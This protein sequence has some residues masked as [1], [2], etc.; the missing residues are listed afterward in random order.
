MAD[1]SY[2]DAFCVLGRAL[3]TGPDQPATVDELLGAMDHFGIHE[4]LAIDSLCTSSNPMA[5]NRR[6]LERTRNQPRLH[7]AWAG[8]MTHSREFPEPREFVAQMRDQGVGA[9][10]LFY[11]QWA[12]P[13]EDWAID[14]LLAE[15]EANRAPLFLCPNS[16]MEPGRID[17]SDWRNI[18][19]LCRKFPDLPVVVTENRLYRG[20]RPLYEALAACPNLK[21]DLSAL[22]LHRRIEFICREFGAERLVWGSCLPERGPGASLMQLNY[23]DITPEELALIAGG[24]LRNLLSWN[25]KVEPVGSQVSFPAPVDSLHRKVRERASFRDEKFYDCHGHIGWCCPYHV[26]DDTPQVLVAEMDKLGV[27]VTCVFSLQIM[28]D[29]EYGTDE[30]LEVTN[31]YPN[32]FIGFT[33]VNPKYGEKLMLQELERGL[34]LGMQG[35]KLLPSAYGSYDVSGPLIDVA[36]RFAHEHK[37]MILSHTW[38]SADRVRQLCRDFPDAL[39]ISGHSAAHFGAVCQEFPNLY[40]CTCPFLGWN[41]T[42]HFVQIYGA[43]RL[44]FGS[45][46]MDLPIAWGLGPIL[47]AKIS[48]ADKR[49]ILGGNLRRLMDQYHTWPHGWPR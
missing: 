45:D 25:P 24:N 36:C 11:G 35:V 21:I 14:D 26:I 17:L 42:E 2:F 4:A 6:I 39:L 22:W 31:A 18:V 3:H 44:L 12:I 10:F 37:Q 8:L 29:A 48:E 9:L 46:L 38:G 27:E 7:P 30:V 41:S 32:R 15:L 19:R 1:I 49:K 28:G 5:G 33:Y 23:S 13:L 16:Q 40:I 34:Q 43:D 20:Q 47:Y